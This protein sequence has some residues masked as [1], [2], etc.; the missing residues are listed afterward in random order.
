MRL[1]RH[2][3]PRQPNTRINGYS[4][5]PPRNACLPSQ[6]PSLSPELPRCGSAG[7]RGHAAPLAAPRPRNPA[8]AELRA[9]AAPA[10]RLTARP[11]APPPLLLPS[12]RP[13]RSREGSG[14]APPRLRAC[15]APASTRQCAG[16]RR[17]PVCRGRGAAGGEREPRGGGAAGGEGGLQGNPGTAERRLG[18][19]QGRRA[20]TTVTIKGVSPP[21]PAFFKLIAGVGALRGAPEGHLPARQCPAEPWGGQPPLSTA[22]SERCLKADHFSPKP[23]SPSPPRRPAPSRGRLSARSPQQR[24]P[25]SF[26]LP[27]LHHLRVF[28][29]RSGFHDSTGCDLQVVDDTS[30]M[31]RD[32]SISPRNTKLGPRGASGSEPVAGA[33]T[34]FKSDFS[35]EVKYVINMLREMKRD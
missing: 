9:H 2:K 28:K 33:Q 18:G 3:S 7:K 35:Q 34:V 23:S 17:R 26:I 32:R 11:A 4:P 8:A 1:L 22:S 25:H 15:A 27:F 29:E 13:L 31:K 21:S 20:A 24:P 10:P 30:E 19:G 5:R 14:A 12:L 6:P 16:G